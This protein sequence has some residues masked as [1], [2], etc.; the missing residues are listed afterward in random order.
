MF[1]HEL[2][3]RQAIAVLGSA[4]IG[5]LAMK[6]S[7]A[8]QSESTLAQLLPKLSPESRQ[9][10]SSIVAQPAFSGQI[11]AADVKAILAS[12]R[13]DMD[14]LMISLLPL[15]RTYS[16]PPISKYLVGTVVQGKD[17]GL[18]LGANLELAGHSLNFSV[19][20]E[21]SAISNA[22]LHG[23]T[24]VA[25]VAVTAAPCGHCRQ[26]M[27]ELTPG[28][29]IRILIEGSAA[30]NLSALLPQSFGPKDLGFRE[31]VFPVRETNLALARTQSD[32]L[33]SAALQ[34]ARRSY[35]PYTKS[36]SGVAISAHNR[37]FRGSYIENA[38][39]N[40][41][42]PPLQTALAALIIAGGDYSGITKVVL[43]EIENA[44][45][46]QRDV[47]EAA[48]S[49]IAPKAELRVVKARLAG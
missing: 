49:T 14:A 6:V 2:D 27:N 30:V 43:A 11:P 25:A 5:L 34:A 21:Q 13:G 9:R 15:A 8:Q 38:A 18:Y 36:H 19:H 20:G 45:I 37:I 47:T 17:G 23:D 29:D 31:G 41:S 33:V 28:S 3:R 40:P 46:S 10:V 48:L 16:R 1:D 42:L 35:A 39:F 44:A 24:G 26:F 32:D 12:E 7:S 4:G 22:Y